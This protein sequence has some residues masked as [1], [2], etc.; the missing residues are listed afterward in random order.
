MK[1]FKKNGS[2]F[3]LL[4]F[5][6]FSI[7]AIGQD[8]GAKWIVPPVMDIDELEIS[9]RSDDSRF[10]VKKGGKQGVFNKKGEVIM[11]A[12]YDGVLLRTCGWII[13]RQ[14][15][16]QL[17]FNEKVEPIGMPYDKF[18]AFNNGLALVYK[19]D[20]CGLINMK[21]EELVPLKYKT[22]IP[23]NPYRFRNDSEEFLFDALPEFVTENEKR[24]AKNSERYLLPGFK[25]MS[26]SSNT[27][28]LLD[29]KGKT[30]VPSLYFFG[31]VHPDGYIVATF[32][33]KT[34]G[35][36]D[37]KHNTL[38]P[39]TAD[40][41]GEWTATRL[42]PVRSEKRWG[43]LRFP[44][45]E[46]V[47]PFGEYEHIEVYDPDKELFLA[48]KNNLQGLINVRQEVILPFEFTYISQADHYAH[49]LSLPNKKRGFWNSQ[50]G[51]RSDC[52]YDNIQN[53]KDSL[54]IVRKD[55]LWAVL[56]AKN[57][58]EVIPFSTF[59]PEKKGAYFLMHNMYNH[60]RKFLLYGLVTRT[61][62]E[63]YPLDSVGITV[64]P[65]NTFWVQP[66][67]LDSATEC[68]HRTP[69]GKILRTL[70]KVGV[71]VQDLYWIFNSKNPE[72]KFQAT[73]F[74]YLDPPGKERYY[75]SVGR[76]QENLRMVKQGIYFGFTDN[77]GR[78]VIPPAFDAAEPSTDGYIRVKYKG[79]WGVLQ[80][81]KFDYFQ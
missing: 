35:V 31:A 66:K 20:L 19:N 38:Y 68:E 5:I 4:F 10:V 75:Q 24:K 41:L 16:K 28:G 72:G 13:A 37:T 15:G 74:S 12:E 45:G 3:T 17:L 6:L 40:K 76:L 61:G 70:P 60:K 33:N 29:E 64:F 54:V 48:K 77:E 59:Q 22:Y 78:V 18:I 52:I 27:Y 56:D 79:K 53:L 46:E 73:L 43:V 42:L 1:S 7:R 65:D 44:S 9:P 32:D 39:F 26:H 47:I 51:F 2:R 34:W 49:E 23:G 80:N 81:P 36:I 69:G 30:V 11:P 58:R 25:I 57:G 63:V 14:G 50:N 8:T 55:S 21:G 62:K 71:E 67:H